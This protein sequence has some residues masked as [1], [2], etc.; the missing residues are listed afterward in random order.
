MAHVV[1]AHLVSP[2]PSIPPVVEKQLGE[3][4]PRLVVV[5]LPELIDQLVMPRLVPLVI[6]YIVMAYTVITYVVMAYIVM[7]YR[8]MA[9][10]VM[11]YRVMAYVVM[12]KESWPM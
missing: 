8:V 2:A 6:A 4:F 5:G 12:A 9:Y 7:A 10:V 1:M 3:R 11:A